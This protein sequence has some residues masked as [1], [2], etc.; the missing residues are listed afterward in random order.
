[1]PNKNEKPKIKDTSKSCTIT[2]C[3]FFAEYMTT[4]CGAIGG[5]INKETCQRYTSA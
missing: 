2:G 3:L 4:K 5:E 1:M